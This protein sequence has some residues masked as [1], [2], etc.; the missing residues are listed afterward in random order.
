[1][2][3][4]KYK[5]EDIKDGMSFSAFI[6]GCTGFLSGKIT[7]VNSLIYLCQDYAIGARC[8]NTHG[9]KYSW[10][11]DHFVTDLIIHELENIVNINE[12]ELLLL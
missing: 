11:L 10:V 9:F 8:Y 4:L 7:V 12:E 2:E 6:R 1:M 5:L 3:N